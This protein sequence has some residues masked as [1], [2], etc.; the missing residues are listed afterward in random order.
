MKDEDIE[1]LICK[2][3][4][5]GSGNKVGES[6]AI[7]KDILII[8]RGE[9]FIGVPLKHV[10]DLGNYIKVK[11]LVSMD[12]AKELGERWVKRYAKKE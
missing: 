10:E 4:V 8:K 11:G 1:D 7:D 5:D 2:F 9:D 3:V 12:K 6:V